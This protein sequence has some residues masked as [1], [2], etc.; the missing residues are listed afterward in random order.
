MQFKNYQHSFPY[1]L[2][3]NISI[4]WDVQGL[5]PH[6][7]ANTTSFS[8]GCKFSKLNCF[9]TFIDKPCLVRAALESIVVYS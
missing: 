1:Y 5:W 7:S 6:G 9:L 2:S 8:H 4:F 3:S